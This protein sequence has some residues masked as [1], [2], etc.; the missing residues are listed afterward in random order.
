VHSINRRNPPNFSRPLPHSAPTPHAQRRHQQRLCPCYQC[1]PDP[2]SRLL[3][4]PRKWGP[5][6]S[7]RPETRWQWIELLLPP[8]QPG[9]CSCGW[10]WAHKSAT[11]P[12][13]DDIRCPFQSCGVSEHSPLHLV[14]P[15]ATRR[16]KEPPDPL[17]SGER[18]S[19]CR[20]PSLFVL[21][22]GSCAFVFTES[23]GVL[24]RWG[25][26]LRSI[27]LLVFYQ[28]D[29]MGAVVLPNWLDLWITRLCSI[30]FY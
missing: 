12:L 14:R 1:D 21:L 18:A 2:G 9:V 6:C 22:A 29:W 26:F 28:I 10:N 19:P 25:V 20:N 15:W 4:V 5:R 16:K 30:W 8:P 23:P 17:L 3:T 13:L 7:W 11:A 24:I 27:C